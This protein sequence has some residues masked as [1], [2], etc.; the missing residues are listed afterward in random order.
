[1]E[2]TVSDAVAQSRYEGHLAGGELVGFVDYRLAGDILFLTHTEVLPKFE[3]QGVASTVMSAV[4][5]DVRARKMEVVLRCSYAVKFV[6]TH[7]DYNDLV[8]NRM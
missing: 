4:L 3:G 7:P 5:N 1:M 6:A 8:S 2:L